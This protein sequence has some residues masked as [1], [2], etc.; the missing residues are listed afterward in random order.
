M[1]KIE[2]M[3]DAQ[4]ETFI[5]TLHDG[6]GRFLRDRSFS[7]NVEGGRE[8]AFARARCFMEGARVGIA[9]AA[10]A[11]MCETNEGSLLGLYEDCVLAH[12]RLAGAEAEHPAAPSHPFDYSHLRAVCVRMIAAGWTA[13]VENPVD[14]TNP[15][16]E[17]ADIGQ[18]LAAC[19]AVDECDVTWHRTR[20]RHEKPEE[21]WMLVVNDRGQDPEEFIADMTAGGALEDVDNNVKAQRRAR[22]A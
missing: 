15:D 21:E 20:D 4:T 8:H 13:R 16:Y 12:E 17:G 14:E 9:Q 6:G 5:V 18:I 22:S 19:A 11:I 3:F 10:L 1:L 2:M 7:V